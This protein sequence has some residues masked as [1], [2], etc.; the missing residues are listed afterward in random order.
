[1]FTIPGGERP[2]TVSAVF[3][4]LQAWQD[5]VSWD[6]ALGRAS[7]KQARSIL[8]WARNLGTWLPLPPRGPAKRS[9]C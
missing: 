3:S 5:L 2:M 6:P 9:T 4:C 8:A 7:A 1:M